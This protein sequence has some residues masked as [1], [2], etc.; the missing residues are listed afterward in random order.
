M[1]DDQIRKAASQLVL[2]VNKYADENLTE[3]LASIVKLHAGIAI[4][5]AFVP[6]PGLDFA[7]LAAN[8]WTMYVRI[9]KEVGLPF[10]KNMVKS[11]ATGVVTNLGSNVVGIL[12]VSSVIKLVP[13][14]GSI[15]G[16]MVLA[17]TMYSV[18]L[19]AGI[20]YMKAL[21]KL[22]SWENGW[23]KASENDVKVA[24]EDVMADKEGIRDILRDSKEYYKKN[25]RDIDAS[26]KKDPPPP[27]DTE[28]N[29]YDDLFK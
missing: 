22:K 21:A 26:N 8:T 28:E 5:G 25:K 23:G 19:A 7:A 9:N 24:V 3:E 16:G 18:T 14:L 20:V 29:P 1:K 27:P 13:G 17:A 10:E 12:A 4:A 11:L 15:G 2:V 6:V